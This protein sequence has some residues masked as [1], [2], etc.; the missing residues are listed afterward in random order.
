MPHEQRDYRKRYTR[1]AHRA[2]KKTRPF[3]HRRAVPSRLVVQPEPDAKAAAA[4]MRTTLAELDR[5]PGGDAVSEPDDEAL[6]VMANA[7][8]AAIR[9]NTVRS[10]T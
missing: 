6:L 1:A 3:T 8:I 10:D 9:K 4:K 5:L 2:A 7:E